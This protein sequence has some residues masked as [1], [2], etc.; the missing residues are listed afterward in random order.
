MN[1]FNRRWYEEAIAWVY[2]R[3]MA[4]FRFECD[5]YDLSPEVL[6]QVM[7]RLTQSNGVV[8]A[9]W[10]DSTLL[11]RQEVRNSLS[12]C[13]QSPLGSD[14][15]IGHCLGYP[16]WSDFP[17]PESSRFMLPGLIVCVGFH[18][19]QRLP[20]YSVLKVVSAAARLRPLEQQAFPQRLLAQPL[21]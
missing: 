3:R 15:C 1:E 10:A 21:R 17:F 9:L 14:G 2:P 8:S 16:L 20:M 18:A 5:D 6:A 7:N 11:V 12:L 13:V 4:S 19:K